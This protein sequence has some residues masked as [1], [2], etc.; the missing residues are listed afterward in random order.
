MPVEPDVV[1]GAA[2][3]DN[4]CV[5]HSIEGCLQLIDEVTGGHPSEQLSALF[6]KPRIDPP[7]PS[8]APTFS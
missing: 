4:V 2:A 1:L 7:C 5:A 8:T 6:G 3:E